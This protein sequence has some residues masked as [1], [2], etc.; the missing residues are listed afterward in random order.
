MQKQ[1]S[2]DDGVF[3]FG[4]CCLISVEAILF[5]FID[6]MYLVEALFFSDIAGVSLPSDFRQ[7]S[8]DFQKMAALTLGLT[9][10]AIHAVKFSLLILFRK[11]IDRLKPLVIYW[12]VVVIYNLAVLGYGTA[13]CYLECP[14]F[15]NLQACKS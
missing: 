13:V 12:W 3:L 5:T 15:Y 6:S 7:E 9:W 10:F 14:Y 11:L 8:F 2:I 4:M 1:F